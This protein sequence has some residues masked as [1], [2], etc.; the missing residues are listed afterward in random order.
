MYYLSFFLD[1]STLEEILADVDMFTHENF[2]FSQAID[3]ME[4]YLRKR[5]PNLLA[6]MHIILRFKIYLN[7]NVIM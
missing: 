2:I 7:K 1:Y 6:G 4:R 3:V 5:S